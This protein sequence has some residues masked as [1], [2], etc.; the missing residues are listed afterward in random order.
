[1]EKWASPY[2]TTISREFC[3]EEFILD[4][5][6]LIENLKNLNE[7]GTLEKENVNL[8][9][10][11]VESLYPSIDPELAMKAIHEVL[12]KDKT[13]DKNT[14]KAIEQF[15]KLSF[16]KAYITFEDKVFKS[17]MG[18]PTGGSLSRQIADIFLHWI[19]FLKAT[20]KI[21]ETKAIKFWNRFIDDCIGVW[22]GSRRSFDN[23]VKTLNEETSM[24]LTS[25]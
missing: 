5:G 10:L 19:L 14:K 21:T 1:M 20:P 12:M 8:F 24:E 22:R 16:D 3:K 17:K 15:I 23:F 4:T 9:T 13:T 7:N 6:N 18:I 25:P 2:L 11:D